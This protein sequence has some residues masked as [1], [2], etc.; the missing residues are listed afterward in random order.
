MLLPRLPDGPATY[1]TIAAMSA[2]PGMLETVEIETGPSPEW[3]VIL[4]HGLGDSGD[5]WAPVVPHVVQ[6]G[7]PSMRFVLPHAPVQPVTINGGMA[8]RSW[9]DIVDLDDI[10]RRADETGLMAAGQA[11]EALIEREAQ[12]GVPASRLVLAGFSQGGAVTLTH[13]L[14]RAEPLAGLVAM[15]T[16]LPLSQR[17]LREANRDVVLPVFMAHGQNDPMLPIRAGELAAEQVRSLGHDVEWHSYP[18]QHE[19]C[20]EELDALATWLSKLIAG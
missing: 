15:S 13:G 3:S 20:A 1:A 18:M 2:A 17:V 4:L 9:Y 7:W 14:R 8:M 6:D 5:G 16:Y 11:V 10:E 12:R 19:A